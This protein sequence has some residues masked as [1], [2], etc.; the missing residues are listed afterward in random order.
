MNDLVKTLADGTLPREK[1]VECAARLIRVLMMTN[2]Y[3]DAVPYGER[4]VEQA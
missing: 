2:G 1:A 3:E 4:F